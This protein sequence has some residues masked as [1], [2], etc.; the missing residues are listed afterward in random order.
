M[1]GIALGTRDV[2]S[3]AGADA[4]S[5]L[6][7]QVSAD[8]SA[9]QPGSSTWA[10]LLQPTGKLGYWVRLTSRTDEFLIDV[11]AGL[12]HDVVRRLQR[13]LL[14]VDATVTLRS[15]WASWTCVGDVADLLPEATRDPALVVARRVRPGVDGVVAT[16]VLGPADVLPEPPPVD[17]DLAAALVAAGWPSAAELRA[18]SIPAELGTWVIH[19]S[20]SFTKG[21]YTGQE[22]VARVDSRGAETPHHLRLLVGAATQRLAVGDTV[23]VDGADRGQVTSVA[24]VDDVPI[25]L[26]SVHRSVAA[27]SSAQAGSI[28]VLV[29][30]AP[31]TGP[32]AAP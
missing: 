13:F 31:Y 21:C 30:D 20:V 1:S 28:D 16:D 32:S 10:L 12:G 18:E 19:E 5:F 4:A 22:L 17:G 3:V 15:E 27:G 26:A 11:D 29:T 24:V 6:Q 8:V 7:G 14:R 2:V 23:T 25:A 9:L